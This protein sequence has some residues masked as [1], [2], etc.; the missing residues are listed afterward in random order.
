[1]VLFVSVRFN[2]YNDQV[3]SMKEFSYFIG[4]LLIAKKNEVS[5]HESR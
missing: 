4:Q 3:G 5:P 1:M 2:H